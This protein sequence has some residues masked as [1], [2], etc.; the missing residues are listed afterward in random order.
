M[1][2]K[3]LS[4]LLTL[5]FLVCATERD[6]SPEE[7]ALLA[8]GD[9]VVRELREPNEPWPIV[10]VFKVLKSSPEHAMALF[11]AYDDQKNYV[12]NVVES[13]PIA[14]TS[15]S[16]VRVAYRLKMGWPV[17][18][19]RYTHDH[20]LKALKQP[21]GYRLDWNMIESTST[22]FVEGYVEFIQH[23]DQQTLMVYSNKVRPKSIFASM[24]RGI[25]VRDLKKSL[26]VITEE[27]ERRFLD[28]KNEQTQQY[29]MILRE[30]LEDKFHWV[31]Q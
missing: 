12:P 4:L 27:I 6:F 23:S 10:T 22:E 26:T 30:S 15:P 5:P 11:A 3:F 16:E 25:M 1:M 20:R 29:L 19:V 24:V 2:K 18:E 28:P 13:K 7:L 31:P 21:A 17:G 9:L 8:Q 14:Q